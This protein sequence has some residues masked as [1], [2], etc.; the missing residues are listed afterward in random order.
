MHSY[1][2]LNSSV[3]IALFVLY[4]CIII[5]AGINNS[6][7][8]RDLKLR[9]SILVGLDWGSSPASARLE[10]SEKNCDQFFNE[11][12]S[13]NAT[14][15]CN[16]LRS[17]YHVLSFSGWKALPMNIQSIWSSKSCNY[18]CFGALKSKPFNSS[19]KRPKLLLP[20]WYRGIPIA[21]KGKSE[22]LIAILAASTSHNIDNFSTLESSLLNK[23]IPSIRNTVECGFRYILLL[24]YDIGD[25]YFDNGNNRKSL[26]SRMQKEFILPLKMMGIY[27]RFL[28]VGVAN[29]IRKPVPVFNAMA[30]EAYNRGADFFYRINDDTMLA[31]NGWASA[32]IYP[33][34][35]YDPPLFG[36]VGPRELNEQQHAPFRDWGYAEHDFVH[37]THMEVFHMQYYPTNFTDWGCDVWIFRVYGKKHA[38]SADSVFVLHDHSHGTRYEPNDQPV[39][40][41]VL[42]GRQHIH[43]WAVT[44][45]QRVSLDWSE[46]ADRFKDN[47]EDNPVGWFDLLSAPGTPEQPKKK[48]QRF[49]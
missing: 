6:T 13:W 4:K 30:V 16:V 40:H 39:D 35:H 3:L 32:L 42:K 2:L 8:C 49:R 31:T 12:L 46:F 24:G 21:M 36:V 7:E 33:L 43:T 11:E 18:N 9:Y 23:L 19:C 28:F 45:K 27:T 44:N 15:L 38:T 25:K 29:Q 37:R 47:A 5:T 20:E 14:K 22:P 1:Y 26:E 48:K 34:L 10:W 17:E 41:Q